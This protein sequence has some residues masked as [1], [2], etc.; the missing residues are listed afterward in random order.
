MEALIRP[1]VSVAVDQDSIHGDM[2]RL[3]PPHL[4]YY[5]TQVLYL[6][7]A[8]QSGS[9]TLQVGSD[10]SRYS[11]EAFFFVLF[12]AAAAEPCPLLFSCFPFLPSPTK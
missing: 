1:H 8:A 6:R 11:E 9:K 5:R 12:V 4:S 7:A 2:S 3:L 10:L